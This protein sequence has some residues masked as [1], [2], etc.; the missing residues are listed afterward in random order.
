MFDNGVKKDQDWRFCDSAGSLLPCRICREDSVGRAQADRVSAIRSED[1]R[2][3]LR[4]LAL[5][6]ARRQER[7][8]HQIKPL[9]SSRG[10]VYS[11]GDTRRVFATLAAAAAYAKLHPAKVWLSGPRL[12]RI[13]RATTR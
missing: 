13:A 8:P 6:T 4:D 10:L 1:S 9:G 5:I 11:V 7:D 2:Q 3:A 12:R